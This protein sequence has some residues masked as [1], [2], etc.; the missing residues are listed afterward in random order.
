VKPEKNLFILERIAPK[1]YKK[2]KKMTKKVLY[3]HE[4]IRSKE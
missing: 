1:K 2:V 3:K 4:K